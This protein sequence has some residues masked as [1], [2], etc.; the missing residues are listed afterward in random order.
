[1][2]RSAKTPWQVV[3]GTGTLTGCSYRT[4]TGIQ[5]WLMSQCAT[6]LHRV[7]QRPTVYHIV[8]KTL[9]STHYYVI[10]TNMTQTKI[11][12]MVLL[13]AMVTLGTIGAAGLLTQQARA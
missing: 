11:V 3:V 12:A 2:F 9:I 5:V 6:K 10:W 8:F 13:L 7:T 4:D 1:M